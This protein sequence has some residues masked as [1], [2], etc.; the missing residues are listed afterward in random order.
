MSILGESK[1]GWVEKICKN[2]KFEVTGLGCSHKALC[3][4]CNL[5]SFSA[6]L[7]FA[8]VINFGPAIH[9]VVT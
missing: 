2:G 3:A 8:N 1:Y 5:Q 4:D 9:R 6:L 7:I